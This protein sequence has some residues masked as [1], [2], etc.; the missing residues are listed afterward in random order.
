[1][2]PRPRAK[3][4]VA[5]LEIQMP[6]S[7]P[8][9]TLGCPALLQNSVVSL[10]YHKQSLQKSVN[11]LAQTYVFLPSRIKIIEYGICLSYCRI[12]CLLRF[13]PLCICF[14]SSR[15]LSVRSWYLSQSQILSDMLSQ[16]WLYK[17]YFLPS[18]ESYTPFAQGKI[19]CISRPCSFHCYCFIPT[20]IHF[21]ES[22]WGQPTC[23]NF[24]FFS[25]L[26]SPLML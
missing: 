3:A 19:K 23:L 7:H 2:V 4:C 15:D 10:L 13:F 12:F 24:L 14:N 18:Q 11:L 16:T 17:Y 22:S 20:F 21:L 1:M 6:P 25:T 26:V 9:S 8:T 5:S